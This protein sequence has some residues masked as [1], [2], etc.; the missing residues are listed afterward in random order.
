MY[1]IGGRVVAVR[2][3]HLAQSLRLAPV[4]SNS[5]DGEAVRSL[6]GDGRRWVDVVRVDRRDEAE[7]KRRRWEVE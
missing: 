2:T 5:A 1:S 4:R 3:L 7:A 6:N